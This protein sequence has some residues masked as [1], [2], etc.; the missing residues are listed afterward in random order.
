M[1]AYMGDA[2]EPQRGEFAFW[3]TRANQPAHDRFDALSIRDA[4]LVIDG[5][6]AGDYLLWDK[7]RDRRVSISIT[8]GP[9][10]YGS[11]IGR[12]RTLEAHGRNPLQ[13]AEV[14]TNDGKLRVR[15]NNSDRTTRVHILATR[16][17]PAYSVFEEFS[18]VGGHAP[19][20]SF[21]PELVSFYA[22][23]RDIGEELA[24]IINRRLQRVFPG[25]MLERPSM[26][27]NPWAVRS[28]ET[29]RQDAAAGDNF[30]RQA[31]PAPASAAPGEGERKQQAAP[32]GWS[33]LDF[34]SRPSVV[35]GNLSPDDNGVVETPLEQL[36][37][38][39]WVHVV[40]VNPLDT[41]VR[42]V[43]LENPALRIRDLRLTRGLD[44]EKHYTQQKKVTAL[45][46]GEKLVVQDAASAKVESYGS[47]RRLYTL[48]LALSSNEQL[49]EFSFILDW[50]AKTPEEKREL[51][52]KH[53]C[54]ELNYFVHRRDPEFF[55]EVVRPYLEN[56][57]DKTFLDDYLLQRDLADYA[58]PWRFA[59]LNT[60][61]RVLLSYRLAE[62]QP[63][64]LRDIQDRVDLMSEREKQLWREFDWALKGN[65]LDADGELNMLTDQLPSLAEEQSETLFG[66]VAEA[67]PAPGGGM[68]GGGGGGMGGM[69]GA[70][71]SLGEAK[72]SLER[73]RDKMEKL[74]QLADVESEQSD[75]DAFGFSMGG[76]M[77]GRKALYQTLDRTQEWAE[78]NYR[79][80]TIEQ[81]LADLV[82][83]RG[84][85]ADFAAIG[86]DQLL[87]S[88]NLTE[89]HGNFT[90][91]MF[92]LSVVDLPFEALKQE[93]DVADG[94][95]TLTSPGSLLVFH[96]EI[97]PA[98]LME[99]APILV[100]Q[101]FFRQN[102]RYEQIGPNTREKYV[103]EE[104]LAGEIYGGHVVVTNPTASQRQLDLLVQIPRG[105]MPVM[106][107]RATRTVRM[108]LGPYHT[109]TYEYY[110]YFPAPGKFVHFP[111]HVAEQEQVVAFGKQF[112]FNVVAELSRIDENSWPYVSQYADEDTV[113]NYLRQKNLHRVNLAEIA[114]RMKDRSFFQRAIAILSQ[115][116]AY[117]HVLWSYALQHGDPVAA[118][119]YLRHADGFV[120]QCGLEL[121]S[122]LLTIDPVER[123]TY[124]HL[125]YKPLVNA[126]AHQLGR[127]RTILN[128]RFHQQYHN[129]LKVLTYER[130]SDDRQR[131]A[132]TYYLLL[133]DRV[134]DA[135]VQYASV[136]PAQLDSRLQYDYFTAYLGF[137]T[138]QLEPARRL[139]DVYANYPVDRWRNAFDA[140]R[141]QLEEI[142]GG[143]GRLI[144]EQ[145]RN[146]Q[147]ERRASEE[148]TLELLVENGQVRL[149]H[150]N[151]RN[152][153]I[154][155]YLMDLEL[156]FSRNPFVQQ[157]A[158]QFSMI[159]PN[160]KRDLE[161]AEGQETTTW[162]LPD[163]FLNRNVLVEISGGGLVKSQAY[164][165]NSMNVEMMQSYG[166]LRVGT[167][168]GP[169]PK[170]YVKVYARTQDGQVK[171]YKDGY[172]DLRGRF[173]Y[174][175]LSTNDLDNVQRF[176]LLVMTDNHGAVVREV[177]PP[178][179]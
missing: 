172:T 124:Q 166:Q 62:Q 27:L 36:D 9:A 94:V 1:L 119:Q 109:E 15:L 112:E 34:L 37:G 16:Y 149:K 164:Y 53:A 6:Q 60:V 138:E 156:L 177:E 98:E 161:L 134:E 83:P 78:N 116:Q 67:A 74:G 7:A 82:G 137:Y 42:H 173:D 25:N 155:Y 165:S 136:D 44:P 88:K 89:P 168:A 126:R 103:V 66:A 58:R 93:I 145:D 86:E 71:R 2:K 70:R 113:L 133:Q 143:S 122:P 65:S 142:D 49:S 72:R 18:R 101:N 153:R 150:R 132:L 26:L 178:K 105:A 129:L 47:L 102:D 87:L 146:Q 63:W 23:N 33:N 160:A 50:P 80:L 127:R 152:V 73:T 97:Q 11:I 21:R 169:L 55:Q 162:S 128:N 14:S 141:S 100:S 159:Q 3:E 96:E 31:P 114:F 111:A 32:G 68:G 135:L 170:S 125:D 130:E 24:Y 84:F 167:A 39:H 175:S 48:Y 59:R 163:E 123:L 8:A 139:V 104:F 51:Y 54:H 12:N 79:H 19:S 46:K 131:M 64:I 110:F 117:D 57:L 52:S 99:E 118:Q 91:I 121:E 40:A 29:S 61:E 147:Q 85:W 17:A 38:K 43:A 151:V 115:R 148:A 171:F 77:M 176:S 108:E 41:V 158:G 107:G 56:K 69:R 95:L 10:E 92:A 35:L 28:T 76:R 157:Y 5:L 140:I 90:E 81:Q 75:M 179:R 20:W 144:D 30:A 22:A 106:N 13:I 120:A 4:M 154:N 174:T 45:G